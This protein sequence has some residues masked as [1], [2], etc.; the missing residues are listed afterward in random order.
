VF[1]RFCVACVSLPAGAHAGLFFLISFS[2]RSAT[3]SSGASCCSSRRL[4]FI[5]LTD[6]SWG[7]VSALDLARA[8]IS[9]P[10]LPSRRGR[11]VQIPFLVPLYLKSRAVAGFIFPTELIFAASSRIL[12]AQH[13]APGE[14]SVQHW[15]RCRSLR[16]IW[17]PH[18]DV[19]QGS[20]ESAFQ[21]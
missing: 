2:V 19:P 1:C 5:F 6:F 10:F 13:T 16:L 8:Q 17:F 18:Q 3:E 4:L 11:R 15:S 21:S 7:Q 9:A 12:S 20:G 14:H